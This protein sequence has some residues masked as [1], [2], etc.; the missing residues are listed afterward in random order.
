MKEFSK[1]YDDIPDDVFDLLPQTEM[2]YWKEFYN[3]QGGKLRYDYFIRD[4]YLSH[5]DQIK[6]NFDINEFAKIGNNI[7]SQEFSPYAIISLF[8]KI[9]DWLKINYNTIFKIE[10]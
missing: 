8:R 2:T 1:T 6:H 9:P 10:G 4:W 3:I 7:Y 5:F